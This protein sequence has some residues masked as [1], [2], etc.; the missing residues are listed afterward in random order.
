MLNIGR[1]TVFLCSSFCILS[2]LVASETLVVPGTGDSS[3]IL[4]ILAADFTEIHNNIIVKIP[5]S[6][7]SGGGI[8]AV[9]AGKYEIARVAGDQSRKVAKYGLAYH[10]FARSPIAFA[11]NE[12]VK[13]ITTLS[14]KQV[15]DIYSGKIKHWDQLSEGTKG[16]KIY[17]IARE[18]G[19][20]SLK[21]IEKVIDGFEINRDSVKTAFSTDEAAG[22]IEKF[23]GTI[24]FL[25]LSRVPINVKPVKF[26]GLSATDFITTKGSSYPLVVDFG[27]IY[28]GNISSAGEKFVKYLHSIRAKSLMRKHGV[29]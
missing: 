21:S 27:I 18:K 20:S 8:R 28:K 16:N 17:V 12:S 2:T 4:K 14:R 19:D 3:E 10:K 23:P 7:G 26:D 25:P 13:V 9:V 6:I 15:V 22:Y 5:P 29:R 1:L 24:A 11:I